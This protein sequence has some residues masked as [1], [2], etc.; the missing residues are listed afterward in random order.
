MFYKTLI[1]RDLLDVRNMKYNNY[2]VGIN[3]VSIKKYKLSISYI[4]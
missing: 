3:E 2:K 1:M 4:D